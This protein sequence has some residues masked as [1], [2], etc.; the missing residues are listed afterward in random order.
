MF[1]GITVLVRTIH[2]LLLLWLMNFMPT[3]KHNLNL[4]TKRICAYINKGQATYSTNKVFTNIFTNISNIKTARFSH[5]CG[6]VWHTPIYETIY[7]HTISL[8]SISL[9][10]H[11]PNPFTS[12]TITPKSCLSISF[13]EEHINEG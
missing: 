1:F 4:I 2:W 5:P 13:K 11:P 7:L 8:R 10:E 6:D 12:T 3:P 9:V